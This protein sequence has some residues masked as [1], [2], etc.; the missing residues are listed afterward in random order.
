MKTKHVLAALGFAVSALFPASA[1]PDAQPGRQSVD[2]QSPAN[3]PAQPQSPKT[4]TEKPS[5]DKKPARKRVVANLSGF[6]LLGASKETMVVGATRDLPRPIALAP[7]LGKVYDLTPSFSWTYKGGA[8][9]YV[10]ILLTESQKEVIRAEVAG[11][12]YRYPADGPRLEPGKTYFWTVQ[13]ALGAL[14]SVEA[15]H[16]GFI[17]VSSDQRAEIDKAVAQT[18]TS[19]SFEGALGRA[20][21]LTSFRLWYDSIAAYTDLIAR[22][23]DRAELYEERGT[24]YAQIDA[25]RSL[26]ERDFARADT[27]SGGPP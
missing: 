7:R 8:E 20:R 21:T 26:A 17:I 22:F 25:T 2:K 14:G 6:D 19:G 27:L 16:V 13:V 5:A 9:K 1:Q 10:F 11:N 24:L 18:S 12:N 4:G 23:P 3:P 15:S